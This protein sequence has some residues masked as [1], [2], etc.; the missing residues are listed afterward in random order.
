MNE[1]TDVGLSNIIY[2]NKHPDFSDE[3]KIKLPPDIQPNDHLLITFS[4]VAIKKGNKVRIYIYFT[5]IVYS[6]NRIYKIIYH[7]GS[8]IFRIFENNE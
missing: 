6:M 3:I 5:R 7:I 2:H 1:F 8:A 4:N